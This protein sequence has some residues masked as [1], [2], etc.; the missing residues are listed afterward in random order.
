DPTGEVAARRHQEGGVIEPRAA[1]V[2]GLGVGP[3]LEVNELH[4]AGAERGGVVAAIDDR[5]PEHVAIEGGDPVEV[6]HRKADRADMERRAAGEGRGGGRVWGIHDGYIDPSGDVRN[7]AFT[8]GCRR[9]SCSARV[10]SA[11]SA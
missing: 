3:M 8:A 6:A 11:W 4:A 9:K 2:V 1:G 7:S 10:G 5:E